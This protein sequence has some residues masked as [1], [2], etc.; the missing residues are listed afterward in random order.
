MATSP[1]F[2]KKPTA[3]D[4]TQKFQPRRKRPPPS[5][6]FTSLHWVKKHETLKS[7]AKYGG[8]RKYTMDEIKKHNKRDDCWMVLNGHVFD[9]TEYIPYHPGGD[10]ILKAKGKDGTVL[11][12]ATHRW[13][14]IEALIKNCWIGQVLNYKP[15]N[16]NKIGKKSKKKDKKSEI[17]PNE[18]NKKE[19]LSRSRQLILMKQNQIAKDVANKNKDE[20]KESE[21]QAMNMKEVEKEENLEE[22]E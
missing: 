22:L 9:V 5:Q 6:G 13:V 10:E 1:G 12:Y 16:L 15:P 4:N 21:S 20:E 17:N 3:H 18:K 7:M 8:P 19:A 14:N 11:F 2:N